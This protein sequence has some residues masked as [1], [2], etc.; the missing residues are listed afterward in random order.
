MTKTWGRVQKYFVSD[1][2]F[3]H[4]NHVVTH[5][6][7]EEHPRWS[8]FQGWHTAGINIIGSFVLGTLAGIPTVD[9]AAAHEHMGITARTR[10]MAGVGFCGSFTT[11]STFSVD[12]VNMLGKG[13]MTRACSYV[14]ANNAGGILMAFA[15]FN[16]AK[17]ILGR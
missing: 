11:F 2:L 13:E 15:G 6:I 10:L 4:R 9:P 16:M 3:R 17:R 8:Y 7:A 1:D 12:V 14:A 5:K